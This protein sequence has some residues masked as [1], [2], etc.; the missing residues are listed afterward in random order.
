GTFLEGP[1]VLSDASQSSVAWGDYDNDGD[2]DVLLSGYGVSGPITR[3][4]RNETPAGNA[5][6]SAPTNLTMMRNGN[7][8]TLSWLGATDDHTPTAALTYNLRIGTTPVGNQV[9]PAMAAAN[10]Y[11]RIVRAGN[12]QGRTSW[13][14]TLPEGSYYWGVQ[15]ID[16]SFLGSQFAQ[17]GEPTGLEETLEAPT[18]HILSPGKPNP[19][20]ISTVLTYAIPSP[21][22]VNI[23][24]F[25]AA[26]RNVR[27][28]VSGPAEAGVHSV[29]WDGRDSEG[30]RLAA[31]VYFVRFEG[32]ASVLAQKVVLTD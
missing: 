1:S 29:R 2:L 3:V 6:P 10:G 14:L 24:V 12:V 30:N 16:G 26:G 27:T 5:V 22:P 8:L 20:A 28:L 7:Q 4:Y 31:G 17:G 13:T 32:A 9:L 23:A 11:R 21:S 25:D 15:A 18:A 19:F